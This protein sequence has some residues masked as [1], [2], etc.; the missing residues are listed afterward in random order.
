[1]TAARLYSDASSAAGTTPQRSTPVRERAQA[2]E[3]P[4]REDEAQLGSRLSERRERL[5]QPDVV[6]VRPGPRGIEEE[7][8]AL[9]VSGAEE[10]VV[11]AV[12]DH[13]DGCRVE[14]EQ[15]ERPVSH[16]LAGHDDRGGRARRAVVGDAPER[17][18]RGT[19]ELREIPML[20]VVQGDDGRHLGRRDRHGER[21]V[22]DVD[23]LQLALD[24]A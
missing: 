4:S 8:L 21:V 9:L 5:E 16:E 13:V 17:A 11:D 24:R 1:M 2:F 3:A 6:L 7:R 15:L 10:R 22:D 14:L 23:R 19:E 18:A 12:R 20:H